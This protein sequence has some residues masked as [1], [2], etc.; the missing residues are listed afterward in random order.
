M[1]LTFPLLSEY[2]AVQ[3]VKRIDKKYKERLFT[4]RIK[5]KKIVLKTFWE[6]INAIILCSAMYL[7]KLEIE[8]IVG[9]CKLIWNCNYY[10]DIRHFSSIVAKNRVMGQGYCHFNGICTNLNLGTGGGATRTSSAL[11]F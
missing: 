9:K 4:E 8:L 5:L 7:V 10:T 1:F 11:L 2:S 3:S 6:A